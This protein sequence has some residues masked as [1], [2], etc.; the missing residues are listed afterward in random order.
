MKNLVFPILIFGFSVTAHGQQNYPIFTQ[1]Y[2]DPFLVNPSFIA[3]D[4]RAEINATFRQQWTGISDGPKT[5]QLDFQYPIGSRLSLGL[6]AYNDKT[7]LL[8]SSGAL[9]TFGYRVRLTT[10]HVLGFAI[11]GGFVSNQI[12]LEDV[13]DIDLMDPVLLNSS[14]NFG[15]DAQFGMHYR[16]KNL[17][18]GVSLLK[19]VDNRP[20]SE[21]SVE[22][23]E[24]DPFKDRT[25]YLS[26]VFN[27][28]PQFSIQPTAYY[29]ATFTGY[30]YYE[31]ALLL[32]YKNVLT[33]GGGYRSEL[34]P[35]A[36]IRI[37][38]KNLQAGYAYDFPA[39]RYGGS[40]G[41]TNEIQ[42]KF[43]FGRTVEP[44]ESLAKEDSTAGADEARER[45]VIAKEDK[46]TELKKETDKVNQPVEPSQPAVAVN[47]EE[48]RE[49]VVAPAR[50]VRDESVTAKNNEEREKSTISEEELAGN[51][52]YELVV[53]VYTRPGHASRFAKQ[54]NNQGIR[55][56]V[57]TSKE[58]RY[59]Y[60][61]VPEY[62]TKAI[63]LD[64]ILE[65][66]EKTQ[67]KDA[68]FKAFE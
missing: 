61:I 57:L 32:N 31:G 34:G 60:V 22:Q 39:T 42:L 38:L 62:A 13:P 65:I 68:W 2:A 24:F 66:R 26:Y 15:F 50:V 23:D 64:R 56:R 25:A 35:H 33:I 28:S 54:L 11:S 40:T 18:I 21:G 48:K 52:S 67:F 51:V 46:E 45:P 19:L 3:L 9:A 16:H 1:N 63:T 7:I 14:N 17:M 55:T 58:T 27:L 44:I 6:N 43:E 36:V 41:G 4:R 5:M 12:D 53:G 8:S 29:R 10:T 20:F 59:Y 30:E 49:E 37:R 47:K